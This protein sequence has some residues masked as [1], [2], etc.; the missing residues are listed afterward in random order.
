M[1]IVLGAGSLAGDHRGTM[2][3][4]LGM[5]DEF[6]DRVFKGIH[7]KDSFALV[8]VLLRPKSKGRISLKSKSPFQWPK[9]EPNFMAEEEDVT[10]MI[11]GIQMVSQTNTTTHS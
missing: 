11:E 9:M 10:A 6:Y 2:R 5:P 4:L 1:E 7:D 3:D 8:P